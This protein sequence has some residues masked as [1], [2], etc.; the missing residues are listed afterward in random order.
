MY[1]HKEGNLVACICEG[2]AELEIMELLLEHDQLPFIKEDLIN[3]QFLTGTMRS[4][5]NLETRYLTQRFDEG[6]Q[7][8]IIR[9]VDSITESYSI[10]SP[11]K[12][13][14]AGEVINCYTRP[15]IEMLII[16]HQNE[17]IHFK[18]SGTPKPSDFC[19]QKLKMGKIIKSKGFIRDYFSN[20][21]ELIEALR[22][23]H[24]NRPKKREA[25]IYSLLN[26]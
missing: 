7:V 5:K 2:N 15:E 12:E 20:I 21:D 17:Y 11:F 16:H 13:K 1:S 3:D 19:I 8:E 22:L 6:Q 23:Y 25:S 10:R 9:I 26:V 14:I 4:A 18:N 24:Q